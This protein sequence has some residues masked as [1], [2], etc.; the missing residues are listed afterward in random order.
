MT[1]T[2]LYTGSNGQ[3]H[4]EQ[5]SLESHPELTSL[6][7]AVGVQLRSVAAG[8][9][10]DWHPA[11]RR[12]FVIMLSGSMEIGLRDGTLHRFGPGDVLLAE[13]VSGTGHTRRVTGEEPR[14]TATIP[15]S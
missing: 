9:F 6:M 15:L 14:I 13:D 11:P 8:H 5:L 2:R 1:I 3:S 7:A 4:T 10:M 12:Q